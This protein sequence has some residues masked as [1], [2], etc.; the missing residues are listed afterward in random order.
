MADANPADFVKTVYAFESEGQSMFF[1]EEALDDYLAFVAK[2][3]RTNCSSG[4]GQFLCYSGAI[5][6]EIATYDP[7]RPKAPSEDA[8]EWCMANLAPK[9]EIH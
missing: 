3:I 8:I 1:Y 4:P 2:E 9:L 5:P 7:E 6:V